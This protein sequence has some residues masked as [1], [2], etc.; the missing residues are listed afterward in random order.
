MKNTPWDGGVRAVGL[1]WSPLIPELRR[2]RIMSNLMDISDWV[3]T[4]YEAA[5][6]VVRLKRRKLAN[7]RFRR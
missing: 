2:S 5:G 7:L 6:I 1:L 4:L 3:P